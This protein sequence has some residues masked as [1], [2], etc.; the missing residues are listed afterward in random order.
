MRNFHLIKS[1]VVFLCLH[2]VYILAYTYVSSPN[3]HSFN[4]SFVLLSFLKYLKGTKGKKGRKSFTWERSVE[5][6]ECHG[7][8]LIRGREWKLPRSNFLFDQQYIEHP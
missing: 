7:N 8:F 5:M 4:I 3:I 6:N 1:I 2:L